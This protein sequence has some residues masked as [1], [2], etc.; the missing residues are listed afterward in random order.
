MR[1]TQFFLHSH[2]KSLIKLIHPD[3]FHS[4]PIFAKRN[5]HAIVFLSDQYH[6]LEQD[7]NNNSINCSS[8]NDF[9]SNIYSNK[10]REARKKLF[11]SSSKEI[12]KVCFYHKQSQKEFKYSFLMNQPW[13]ENIVSFLEIFSLVDLVQLDGAMKDCHYEGRDTNKVPFE[14]IFQ[15]INQ[16]KLMEDD[17]NCFF[18]LLNNNKIYFHKSLSQNEKRIGMQNVMRNFRLM[19]DFF[20]FVQ[21]ALADAKICICKSDDADAVFDS[22]ILH[23]PINFTAEDFEK[24]TLNFIKAYYHLFITE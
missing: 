14:T 10:K 16:Q 9:L 17:F 21:N 5:E 19:N 15:Q 8:I 1:T 22:F 13:S 12:S 7:S 3:Y 2:W 6:K 18:S 23:I 24:V 20:D 4:F 11:S